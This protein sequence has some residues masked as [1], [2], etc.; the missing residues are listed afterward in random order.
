MN[1]S[2]CNKPSTFLQPIFSKTSDIEKKYI[3]FGCRMKVSDNPK[4]H[5]RL[6]VSCSNLS[7]TYIEVTRSDS[8][9]ECF[10][11]NCYHSQDKT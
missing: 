4:Y 1:C 10:C 3:C 7:P 5:V 11:K 6:C 8:P 2:Y 9:T